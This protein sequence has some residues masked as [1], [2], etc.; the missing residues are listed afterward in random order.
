MRVDCSRRRLCPNYLD[1]SYQRLGARKAVSHA[2]Q[3][4]AISRATSF[5]WAAPFRL[6]ASWL[7]SRVPS[8]A[9]L[10]ARA[11]A[12]VPRAFSM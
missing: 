4:P 1:I 3:A 9:S 7:F 10:R 2:P 11:W 12:I 8:V 5:F 6:M